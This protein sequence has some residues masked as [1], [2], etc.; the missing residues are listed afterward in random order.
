MNRR[1]LLI[2]MGVL[3]SIATTSGLLGVIVGPE[4]IPGGGPTTA[5]VDSE[6]RFVNVF[7]LAAGLL[8]L[9]SLRRAEEHARLARAI[10]VIA[11]VGGLARLLSVLI[12]GWPHPVFIATIVLE[13]AVVPLVIWWHSRVMPLRERIAVSA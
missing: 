13:L 2:V 6:Y 8:L 3:G 9:W 7:W 10:L 11:A 4:G 12:V 5:S 1:A